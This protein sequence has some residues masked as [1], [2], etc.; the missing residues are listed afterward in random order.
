MGP[1]PER[2]L[3]CA[4]ENFGHRTESTM[5]K[6]YGIWDSGN[7]VHNNWEKFTLVDWLAPAFSYS[8]CGNVHYPPNGS[9]DYD[10]GN[11]STVNTNCDD[12]ANYPNLSEPST[13]WHPVTCSAWSCD[14][15]QYFG[16]WFGHLAT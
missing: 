15:L 1:S 2:G 10:Y 8:G 3:D 9:S 14:H 7:P 5:S 16:Y 12:F 4:I 13:V 6:V 11:P